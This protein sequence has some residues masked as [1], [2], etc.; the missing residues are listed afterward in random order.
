MEAF[1]LIAQPI[2]DAL[3]ALSSVASSVLIDVLFKK[4]LQKLLELTLAAGTTS[5][6]EKNNHDRAVVM[7]ELAIALVP[8][9][10]EPSIALL[11]D[12]IKPMMTMDTN[13][14]FQKRC[15]TTVCL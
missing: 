10:T 8:N 2:L 1:R 14:A 6:F 12:A 13:P 5:E 4:L 15:Y 7:C 11:Y 9:L 3:S